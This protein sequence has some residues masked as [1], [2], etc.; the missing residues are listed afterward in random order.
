M[1]GLLQLPPVRNRQW[2]DATVAGS[3]EPRRTSRR[4]H[5]T[6]VLRQLHWLPFRHRIYFKLAVLVFKA[7]CTSISAVYLA[8]DSQLVN[9][10]H[11]TLLSA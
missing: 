1:A 8:D 6:S 11:Q 4:D 3:P 5:I 9:Y 10:D 7:R 2:P